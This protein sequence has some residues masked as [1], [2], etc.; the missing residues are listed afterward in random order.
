VG[1]NSAIF[2]QTGGSVGI[3]FASRQPAKLVPELRR[4]GT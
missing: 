1:I 3:G 2:S 4:P